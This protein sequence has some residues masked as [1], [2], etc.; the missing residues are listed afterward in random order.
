MDPVSQS[1]AYVDDIFVGEDATFVDVTIRLDAPNLNS[2]TVDYYFSSGTAGTSDYTSE[3]SFVTFAA[4]ETEQTVRIVLK[5][6]TSNEGDEVF[7]VNLNGSSTNVTIADD[8]GQVWI[9]DNDNSSGTPNVSVSSMVVDEK[10]GTASFIVTLDRP[11]V[12]TVT[13]D[14]ATQNGDAVAGS[15][16]VA[17][18]GTLVFGAGEVV[19]TVT[20]D[21]IDDVTAEG[22]ED[23][24][25]ALSNLSG[26]TSIEPYGTALIWENDA[27]AVSQSNVFVDDIYVGEDKD[28]VDVTIRLDSPN[29]NSATVDYYVSNGTA[30]SA[31][32]DGADSFVTFAAGETVKTVR[33]VLN[34]DTSNEG[35]EVFYVNLNGSSANVSIA[36]DRAQVWIVDNDSSTGTPNVSVSS[37]VVDEKQGTASFIVTL[38]RPSVGTVTMDYATQNGD[39]VAGSDYVAEAGTLV[40]G[41]GEV[42]KTVTVDLIDDANT[43]TNQSF[44]LALSNLSGA[45]SSD[46]VGTA[47]IWEND[48]PPAAQSNVVI[49]D[50]FVGEDEN[51]VD[52]TI[53][54]D[55][56]NLNSGTVDYYVSN[57]TATSADYDGADSF[58]TFA[59]G[60]T[61]K[62]VRIVLNPDFSIEGDEVF[63]FNL[64]GSS[65]N[66]LR[67]DTQATITIFDDDDAQTPATDGINV[68]SGTG[69]ADVIDGLAGDDM[70]YGLGG[71]DTL[72]GGADD[73]EINGGKGSDTASYATAG[74]RV[75]VDLSIVG[76]QDTVGAGLDTLVSIEN[77][78]GSAYNDVLTGDGIANVLTGGAGK[79]QLYGGWGNDELYG[80]VGNDSLY[81]GKGDD[82]MVGGTGDDFYKVTETGDVVVEYLNQGIDQIRTW[83]NYTLPSN[84]E[85]LKL[86]GNATQG[87]GNELDN[88]IRA[89]SLAATLLGLAGNDTIYGNIG[90]DMLN[91]GDDN[92]LLRGRAG[93][94][95]LEG[96]AGNDTL[97]G[98]GGSDNLDGGAGDD[99]LH[100]SLGSDTLQGAWGDDTLYGDAG[101][102]TLLGGSQNDTLEG[103]GGDD[104]LAGNAGNDELNGGGGNDDL[105]GGGDNDIL[106]GA[107]G[108][109]VL[110]GGLGDDKLFG[111]QDNDTL[112][113]GAG[114][115]LLRGDDGA[116]TFSF[117]DGDF[118]GLTVGTADSILDFTSGEGDEIDLS[119]VDAIAGGGDN[120]F[121]FIGNSAF[122]GSAGELRW[123]HDSGNTML[124]MDIN[125]DMAADYAIQLVG[126]LNL[127]GADFVL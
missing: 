118:A 34:P 39:A 55:E 75:F 15:D 72:E 81:G 91:G 45:T 87:T 14:Y 121:S 43:E 18:A 110:E 112:I 12:G 90:D 94:D 28:Y 61:V 19:K 57:G 96:E 51:Y 92:D 32:Y 104:T 4:G 99:E 108:V 70:I 73:D 83:V 6:D 63:Y 62:T 102:D 53:R 127:T 65:A 33:I 95:T 11:S 21:L 56:P 77:L 98:G 126:T 37:M 122:S 100:G 35:D 82:Y 71:K 7:Y 114:K 116:D 105:D 111:G 67:P 107:G 88:I 120:A 113:G 26:A 41:A 40:F 78:T 68:I 8:R 25:L 1:N 9:V 66:I 16:Y 50:V 49:D 27:P 36:D 5:P 80:D 117:D 20:V 123:E 76:Q 17:E 29:L 30:T 13:M 79:D 124:Y 3:D 22:N 125:G 103:G 31:D 69:N 10:Q 74:S 89:N 109:D 84:V 93:A 23:F 119:L 46:P 44:Q 24:A 59:A 106:R 97:I 64:N 115:D 60:E 52:V 47:L 86:S 58:V 85:D 54:L 2:A 38:D 101:D 48:A 42:V